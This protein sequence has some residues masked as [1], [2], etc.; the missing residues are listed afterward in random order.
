MRPLLAHRLDQR[1]LARGDDGSHHLER[2]GEGRRSPRPAAPARARPAGPARNAGRPSRLA[3]CSA[4]TI[5]RRS[6]GTSVSPA[7]ASR[8][9]ELAFFEPRRAAPGRF[10][11]RAVTYGWPDRAPPSDPA[12][13]WPR[14]C[15]L[16]PRPGHLLPVGQLEH[17]V[18]PA[19]RAGSPCSV[20]SPRSPLC[21]QP[22]SMARRVSSGGCDTPHD[23]GP[24]DEDLAA[25]GE[26]LDGLE[27]HRRAGKRMPDHAWSPRGLAAGHRGA[28]RGL[29][30]APPLQQRDA[31]L[32]N[33][34]NAE[35]ADGK[36]RR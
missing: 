24:A 12:A 3:A 33:Q 25:A 9:G 30:Q 19:E 17:G 2:G 5:A 36:R 27:L 35:L 14:P 32:S 15:A 23:L 7:C 4:S 6:S 10:Q 31:V 1:R 29:G 21:S 22:P 16:P 13:A 8:N 26:A 11:Q 20:H 34:E 28:G 18:H